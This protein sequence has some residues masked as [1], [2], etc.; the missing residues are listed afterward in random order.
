M[1][2]WFRYLFIK[3]RRWQSNNFESAAEDEISFHSLIIQFPM[4]AR[5]HS[6]DFIRTSWERWKSSLRCHRLVVTFPTII[7]I[8]LVYFCPC[9]GGERWKQLCMRLSWNCSHAARRRCF[10]C[11]FYSPVCAVPTGKVPKRSILNAHT[12]VA[13]EPAAG[14]TGSFSPFSVRSPP[15][16]LSQSFGA[17]SGFLVEKSKILSRE[18]KNF[19]MRSFVIYF[20]FAPW[21]EGK[22]EVCVIRDELIASSIISR[23]EA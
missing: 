23:G 16:H 11:H 20:R 5:T 15:R 1:A 2:F 9:H 13:D 6:S 10:H 22:L 7:F 18:R 12:R 3:R 4:R 8:S 19:L 21:T 14:S 17:R